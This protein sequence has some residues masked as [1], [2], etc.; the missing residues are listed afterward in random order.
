MCS[1]CTS[2]LL[3]GT[4]LLWHYCFSITDT[5]ILYLNVFIFSRFVCINIILCQI[6]SQTMQYYKVGFNFTGAKTA[7]FLPQIWMAKSSEMLNLF[8]YFSYDT[9]Y[10][11]DYVCVCVVNLWWS[12]K[13]VGKDNFLAHYP[14]FN[15]ESGGYRSLIIPLWCPCW[16]MSLEWH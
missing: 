1:Q 6:V 7:P 14:F 2:P 5:Y 16:H 9:W 4:I 15:K 13:N 12:G 3:D 8:S 11:D 10:Y